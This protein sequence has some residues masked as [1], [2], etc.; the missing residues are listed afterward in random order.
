MHAVPGA[1]E[2]L[3][4]LYREAERAIDEERFEDAV[5]RLTR[6]IAIDDHFRQRWITMY[7]QRA[8]ALHRLRRWEEAI[9]DYTKALSMGEPP[10][11]Q[12]QYH[13]HR[14][15]CLASLEV[16]GAKRKKNLEAAVLDYT[17]SIELYPDHPGPFRMRARAHE[18]LGHASLA[19]LDVGAADRLEGVETKPTR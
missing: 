4:E 15:L 12:A 18:A 9:A 2:E 13:F 11:H 10:I 19:R 1:W 7:A 3:M 14:G 5:V 6:G 16:I 8:F 17:R